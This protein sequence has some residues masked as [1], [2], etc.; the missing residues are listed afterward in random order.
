MSKY[1]LDKFLFTVD[2]DPELVER[3]REEPRATVEWWEAEEAGRILGSHLD[4]RSTWLSFDDAEREA[5]ATHDYPKLFELGAHPF[6]TL[7]LFIAM[8]ERD[9]AKPLGFQLEYAQRLSGY[10]LP[11]PDIST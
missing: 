7:T 6:L 10:S 4:E 3:Y 8:F 1:L 5:L 9:Y 11:Y 2:R